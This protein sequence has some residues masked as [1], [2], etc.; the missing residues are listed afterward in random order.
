MGTRLPGRCL[1]QGV[2]STPP[3]LYDYYWWTGTK[4]RD[5]AQGG[6]AETP[7]G[8]GKPTG[9]TEAA[10]ANPL[11]DG[12]QTWIYIQTTL[13]YGLQLCPHKGVRKT[14]GSKH[15][16]HTS[17]PGRTQ[18]HRINC[19]QS[20]RSKLPAPCPYCQKNLSRHTAA[21]LTVIVHC[22][23]TLMLRPQHWLQ[24]SRKNTGRTFEL[25]IFGSKELKVGSA[26]SCF[27]GRQETLSAALESDLI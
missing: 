1:C 16:S 19:R 27:T 20:C 11:S 26:L 14:G 12:V 5:A 7:G 21:L 4:T 10:E 22:Q 25:A 23:G 3:E 24:Q 9:E 15:Y 6:R 2:Y 13:H 17:V 8:A 18:Q